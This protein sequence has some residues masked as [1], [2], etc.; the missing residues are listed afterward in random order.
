ME[1]HEI[2]L[3]DLMFA[4]KL[5]LEFLKSKGLDGLKCSELLYGMHRLSDQCVKSGV[6][7]LDI[8]FDAIQVC[9]SA[10]N[11]K[12]DYESSKDFVKSH[13]KNIR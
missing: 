6:D 9:N 1:R 2:D 5:T 4:S 13:Q 3:D 10:E 11:P 8:L 12:I 7:N